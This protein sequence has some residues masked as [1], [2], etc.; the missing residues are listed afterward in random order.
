MDR[1]KGKFPS[2]PVWNYLNI[3]V[4]YRGP[5]LLSSSI[6]NADGG[7]TKQGQIV[8]LIKVVEFATW[9]DGLIVSYLSLD[10]RWKQFYFREHLGS[11]ELLICV[12]C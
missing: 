12:G 4:I 8:D 5:A 3:L 9:E 1:S 6:I 10:N 7:N 2:T 11:S